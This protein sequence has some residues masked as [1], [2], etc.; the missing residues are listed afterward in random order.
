[1]KHLNLPEIIGPFCLV[2][3]LSSVLFMVSC[4][5]DDSNGGNINPVNLA[6]SYEYESSTFID[7]VTITSQGNEITMPAGS[8][9]DI[10]VESALTATSPCDD[11]SE[12]ELDLREGGLFYFLCGD[13]DDIAEEQGTWSANSDNTQLT[14]TFSQTT[15]PV[16]VVIENVRLED[17]D[18]TNDFKLYGRVDNFPIPRDTD[19]PLSPTNLQLISVDIILDKED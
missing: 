13:D 12:T 8:S 5:D 4:S 14:I 6:G 9:A 19:Q 16:S 15:P 1:M 10:F 3:L 7:E 2:M 11:P 18:D 17:D